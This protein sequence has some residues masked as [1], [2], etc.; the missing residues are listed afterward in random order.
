MKRKRPQK[1]DRLKGKLKMTAKG[2]IVR[3][4]S[5]D[6]QGIVRGLSGDCKGIV[7]GVVRGLSGDCQGVVRGLSGGCQGVGSSN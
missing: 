6:C 4:L 2:D 3:G 1:V 7:T 5:G